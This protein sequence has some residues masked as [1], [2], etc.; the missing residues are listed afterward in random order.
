MPVLRILQ[1]CALGFHS[2]VTEWG[3]TSGTLSHMRRK[4]CRE[5]LQV[6]TDLLY[7]L[8]FYYFHFFL[9]FF[10]ATHH[11]LCSLPPYESRHQAHSSARSCL[12]LTIHGLPYPTCGVLEQDTKC[13]ETLWKWGGRSQLNESHTQYET[14]HRTSSIS[15][16]CCVST[17]W[18]CT[19]V[20]K[21]SHSSA[22]K[23]I[24]AVNN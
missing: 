11:L 19:T 16:Q 21:Y 17:K 12:R 22:E 7:G 13:A 18:V 2:L 20:E 9:L 8:L 14:L 15:Y 5:R 24:V 23:P 1:H 3:P 6:E 10:Y 4:R